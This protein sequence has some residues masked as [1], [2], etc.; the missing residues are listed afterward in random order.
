[1]NDQGKNQ[2]KEAFDRIHAEEAL[3]EHT[4]EYLARRLRRRAASGRWRRFAAAAAC[5]LLVFLGGGS[6]LYFTPTVYIAIDVNPSLELGINRFD[7]VVSVEG[8]NEDGQTLAASL[9]VRF[10]NYQ[11]ALEEILAQDSVEEYLSGDGLLTLTVTGDGGVQNEEVLAGVESCAAG[12]RNIRCHSGSSEERAEALELGLSLERYRAYLILCELDPSVT[13]EE[14]GEMSM[15]EIRDRIAALS[16]QGTILP[17]DGED[18]ETHREDGEEDGGS[19][20]GGGRGHGHR[21]GQEG[22]EEN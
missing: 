3:K 14:I 19:H 6:Y 5:L 2:W 18:S 4:K 11:E 20:G 13:P 15:R 8:Y 1:M 21:W 16:G 7:Q 17:G 22:G 9:H 12:H 10:M